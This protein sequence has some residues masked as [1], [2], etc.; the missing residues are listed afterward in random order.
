MI[1][2]H[3]LLPGNRQR[4]LQ[5]CQWLLDQPD[6]FLEDLLIGDE[7]GFALNATIN[8]HNIRA[9]RLRGQPPLEFDY[10]RNDSRLKITTWV[11]LMG[12]G[13]I[14]GPVFFNENVNGPRYLATINE[15]VVPAL[16][17]ERRYRRQGNGRF[18]RVWWAQ[19][20]AP[21][22]RNRATT[23]R[24][25]EL[26]GERVIA[27]N[28]PVE[29]PPRSPDLTPLD[30][31]LWGHLK[32]KVFVTPLAN[33]EEMRRRITVEIEALRQDRGLIRRAVRDMLTRTRKCVKR[34]GGYIED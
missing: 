10:Q 7:S 32:S 25:T 24:M 15:Q 11:G 33:L 13:T 20:G 31:F 29:W 26:F 22:H 14:L 23:E 18:R 28:R 9:Y 16:A 17:N 19:D 2:H 4:R 12:N 21:C 5:F 34:E 8:T 1:K 3:Q 6:R 30:F 27:L